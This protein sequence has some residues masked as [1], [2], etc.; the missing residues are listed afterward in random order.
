[1]KR[2][3]IYDHQCPKCCASYIPYDDIRCPNCGYR[4]RERFDYIPLLVASLE[5]NYKTYGSYAAPGWYD[6]SLG[7]KVFY[8]LSFLFEEYHQ[9]HLLDFSGS[10]ELW[11]I[12]LSDFCKFTEAFL[13]RKKYDL[14]EYFRKHLHSIAI[15]VYEE[16][17]KR[18]VKKYSKQK[19][20]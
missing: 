5:F 4:E 3:I 12:Y 2:H 7:E 8:I 14:P 11:E 1:M 9:K 18:N 17:Q 15:R 19:E 13:S 16:M 6:N 10:Q 20:D